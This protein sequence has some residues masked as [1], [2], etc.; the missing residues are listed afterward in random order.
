MSKSGD[1]ASR[2]LKAYLASGN[3]VVEPI[4]AKDKQEKPLV[5]K[6]PD[7]KPSWVENKNDDFN[8]YEYSDEK[9]SDD[10]KW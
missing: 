5:K 9:E 1:D 4:T 7:E 3:P 8:E 10:T 6:K 2:T